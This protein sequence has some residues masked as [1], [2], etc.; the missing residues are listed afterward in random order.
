MDTLPAPPA[1][2]SLDLAGAHRIVLTQGSGADELKLLS[3]RTGQALLTLSVSADGVSVVVSG[4]AV[5]IEA[6][7]ILKLEAKKLVL[8]ALQELVVE[9]GGPA[10]LNVAGDLAI[11]AAA[12][13]LTATAGNVRLE[14]NDDVV[15]EGERVMMNCE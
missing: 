6:T 7:E 9:S 1:P 11:T 5:T 13:A 14:A 12:Q 8:S 4:A 15:L 10:S 3:L 2:A